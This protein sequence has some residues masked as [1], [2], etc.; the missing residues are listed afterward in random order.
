LTSPLTPGTPQQRMALAATQAWQRVE[1]PGAKYREIGADLL[2]YGSL[3]AAS[4]AFPELAPRVAAT[5]RLLYPPLKAATS[6]TAVEVDAKTPNLTADFTTKWV[7]WS[8][9]QIR[10]N[11]EAGQAIGP[12]FSKLSDD[13]V[14]EDPSEK[15]PVR[16][17]LAQIEAIR[18]ETSSEAAAA[19]S[20]ALLNKFGEQAALQQHLSTSVDEIQKVLTSWKETAEPP[21]P[22][23]VTGLR[24]VE[25]SFRLANYALQLAGNDDGARAAA[26]IANAAGKVGDL[27]EKAA[28]M[29][30]MMLAAG[31]V[32]VAL[33]VFSALQSTKSNGPPYEAIFA[34]L[35]RISDQIESLRKEMIETL[36]HI[37]ARLGNLLVH[38]IELSKATL[39]DVRSA[40]IRINEIEGLL[41]NVLRD[42]AEASSVLSSLILADEDAKCIQISGDRKFVAPTDSF[43]TCRDIY[44]N[45]AVRFA[46]SSALTTS[47]TASEKF[48]HASHYERLRGLLGINLPNSEPP[49]PNPDIWHD[50]ASKLLLLAQNFPQFV[51]EIDYDKTTNT[52]LT[53]DP[54]VQAGK[55]ILNFQY[56]LCARWSDDGKP[57]FTSAHLDQLFVAAMDLRRAVAKEIS[58]QLETTGSVIRIEQDADQPFN[59][60][61]DFEFLRTGDSQNVAPTLVSVDHVQITLSGGEHGSDFG[62]TKTR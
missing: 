4:V 38:S 2:F 27:V 48:P 23:D 51:R 21:S 22:P 12:Y 1:D 47:P 46:R 8:Y 44:V 45:R 59:H 55:D 40:L 14:K 42:V 3:T 20:A 6:A 28:D 50:G 18:A 56:Q 5:A 29:A 39:A 25:G 15:T 53:I 61:W 34:Q 33:A 35:H 19:S 24:N 16:A 17:V 32:G 13:D 9:E 49:V 30:P 37:D 60:D 10:D 11:T 31:Y 52:S 62:I 36:G 41:Q 58:V 57:S 26:T 7:A 54:I 43:I